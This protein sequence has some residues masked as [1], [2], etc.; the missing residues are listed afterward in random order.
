MDELHLSSGDPEPVVALVEHLNRSGFKL[1]RES[2]GGMGGVFMIYEGT[3]GG[4]PASVQINAD[5][6][7]WQVLFKVGDMADWTT[8]DVW[9]AYLDGTEVGT[10]EELSQQVEFVVT[11]A[12][13]A[14]AA[15]L[16]SPGLETE[17]V[18]IGREYMER[19]Y[20]N[21]RAESEDAKDDRR[22]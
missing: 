17:L 15:F 11:R 7:R 4:V 18:R 8:T 9:E 13:D 20:A 14:A 10:R 22:P 12:A 2:R 5:R 21:L 6:G 16:A 3:I 19:Y 1:V